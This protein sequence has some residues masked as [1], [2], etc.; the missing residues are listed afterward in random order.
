MF[1]TKEKLEVDAK[2]IESKIKTAIPDADVRAVDAG[3]GD[4]FD[5]TVIAESFNGSSMVAQH[6]LVYGALGDAM[7][8]EIH[9]LA[10]TTLTPDQYRERLVTEI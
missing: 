6:R 2:T 5:V 4:H 3:G 8:A 10:L 9:A 7:K 1:A